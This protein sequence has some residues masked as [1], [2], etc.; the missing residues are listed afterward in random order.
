MKNL[1]K[2]VRELIKNPTEQPWLEYKHDNYAPEMIGEDI[3][4]LANS[5]A[6]YERKCA[7]ML[8]GITDDTHEI[9]GTSY[10]LQTLKKG[11]QE[12]ENWL[13]SLLSSNAEFEFH[14]EH[15]DG[16]AIGILIVYPAANQTVTFKKTEYI[17]I[18]SYTKKLADYPNLKMQIWDK[19]RNTRF[20]ER[21]AQLDLALS[22]VLQLLDYPVYFERKHLPPPNTQEGVAHY[23]MEE[24]LLEKLDNGLFAITNLGAITL[25]KKL[26]SFDRLSRKALRVVQYQS[27]NRLEILRDETF[28]RGY[29]AAFSDI[30]HYIGAL[31]PTREP[32]INGLRETQTAYPL[33][34]IRELL[35][36]A[37]IHQDFSITGTGPVVEIFP[38]R[39][40]ITN[41]GAPLVETLRIIDNPPKSRNEKLAALMRKL[42]ICEELGTGWDRTVMECELYQLPAPRINAYEDTTRVTLYSEIPFSQLSLEE[43]LWACYLHVCIKWVNEEPATNS[44]LRHRFGLKDASSSTISRLIRDAVSEKLIKPADPDTAPRYM[45]Y[46]PNWA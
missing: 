31:T 44:T 40:E 38:K 41:P 32:I 27:S 1:D 33:L 29:I 9:V 24:K 16:K 43:R 34:A 25:A 46:I 4:A 39:I 19:L 5:A 13:R 30:L 21:Y 12:L 3:S 18:G 15:I 8:W 42:K 6:L 11:N 35:A 17:R 36:N 45:K 2:L 22:D 37:L 23:L 10:T 26:S 20:E 28:D 7:Y 14:T